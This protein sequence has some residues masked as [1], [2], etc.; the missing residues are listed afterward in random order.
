M[1]QAPPPPPPV[2]VQIIAVRPAKP[3]AKQGL[4][5]GFFRKLSDLSDVEIA[6]NAAAAQ[7]RNAAEAAKRVEAKENAALKAADAA[8]EK[9]PPGRPRKSRLLVPLRVASP[10]VPKPTNRLGAVRKNWFGHPQLAAMIMREVESRKCY[11]EAVDALQHAHSVSGL[12][13]GLCE[14][15]VRGWYLDDPATGKGGFVNLT[16][17]ATAAL[18]RCSGAHKPASSGKTALLSGAHV[19][20]TVYLL[21]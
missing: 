18:Q 5:Q 2:D 19:S 9:R 8:L 14:S 20:S 7:I 4:I 16:P 17:G 21:L 12:F 10:P 13:S 1:A 11:R 15:T 6:A 3:A